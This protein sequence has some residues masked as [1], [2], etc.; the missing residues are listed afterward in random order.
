MLRSLRQ[1]AR[2]LAFALPAVAGLALSIGAST[3]V[4]SVS[5][6]ML[7][8]SMGFQDV[9]RIVALWQGDE[10]HQQK[11][12]EVSYADLAAWRTATDVFD[13]VALASSVNRD[14]PLFAGGQPEQVD[15]TTVTGSFF[16]TLGATPLAG[17]FF[18]DDDDKPGASVRVVLSYSLWRSRFGGDYSAVGRQF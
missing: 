12:V 4:F 6:A 9:N 15:G 8:R 17:R 14:F 16:R 2:T 11:H 18:T 5:S 10:A 7:L 3:A 13:D 1:L